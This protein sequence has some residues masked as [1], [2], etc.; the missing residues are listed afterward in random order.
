MAYRTGIYVVKLILQIKQ[1]L[2]TTRIFQGICESCE[3]LLLHRASKNKTTQNKTCCS[4][5]LYLT[6]VTRLGI[7]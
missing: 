3:W 5:I 2:K 6:S 4:Y 7:F 1:A